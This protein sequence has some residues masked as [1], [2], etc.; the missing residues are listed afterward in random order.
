MSEDHS[1]VPYRMKVVGY[2]DM[3]GTGEFIH[4]A[5]VTQ[6][7]ICVDCGEIRAVDGDD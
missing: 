1:W 6:T 7:V 2:P 3:E 5:Y 4:Q